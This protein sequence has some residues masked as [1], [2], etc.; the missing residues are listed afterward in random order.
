M[1]WG[2]TRS[3]ILRSLQR[4]LDG[5]L[6]LLKLLS[7]RPHHLELFLKLCGSS[8]LHLNMPS[9]GPHRF[10]FFLE[11]GGIFKLLAELGGLSR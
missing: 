7:A 11:L 1:S 6:L 2:L 5:G 4:G 10:E 8:L 3:D 9:M